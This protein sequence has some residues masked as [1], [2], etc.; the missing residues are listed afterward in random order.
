MLRKNKLIVL[1]ELRDRLN[2]E[3]WSG[4]SACP[5]FISSK[6]ID[7]D[8]W[9]CDDCVAMFE[10]LV[11]LRIKCYEHTGDLRGLEFNPCPCTYAEEIAIT[12]LEEYIEEL[13]G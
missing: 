10:N 3:C 13:G 8:I 4:L 2:G 7:G 1:K 12:R 6:L 5:H 11:D 9:T